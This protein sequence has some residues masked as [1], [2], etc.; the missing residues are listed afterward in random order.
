MN[1][2]KVDIEKY[3]RKGVFNRFKNVKCSTSITARIDVTD[4][5]KKSKATNTKFH[6][7]FLYILAKV[8]NSKE[9]YRMGYLRESDEVV[10]YDKLGV[11]HYLFHEDTETCSVVYTDYDPDYKTFYDRCH[12]DIERGKQTHEYGLDQANHPNFFEASYISWISYD[13]LNLELPD[14]YLYFLPLINWGRFREENGRLMM[15]L[16]VRMN[17]CVGDG[18]HIS[19][20]YKLLEKEIANF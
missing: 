14:G 4:L 15:P 20:V 16:T 19:M 11:C 9:D 3:Y 12:E 7:N 17:H 2:K 10:C 1:Y 18:Y 13:S 8:L 5:Y 6:I